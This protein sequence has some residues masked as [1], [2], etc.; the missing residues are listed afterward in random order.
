MK[1]IELSHLNT[2]LTKIKGYIDNMPGIKS[3]VSYKDDQSSIISDTEKAIARNNI[4]AISAIDLNNHLNNYV[5]Y[6]SQTKTESEQAQARANIMAGGSNPNL[7]M[8][9]DFRINQRRKTTAVLNEYIADGW[10]V[11]EGDSTYTRSSG[12][13]ISVSAPTTQYSDLRQRIVYPHLTGK[14]IIMSAKINGQIYV[15]NYYNVPNKTSA[16]V[17]LINY[18]F[19]DFVLLVVRQGTNTLAEL[20]VAVRTKN[21][22]SIT[23][24]EVKLEVGRYSTLA[25]GLVVDPRLEQF[26]CQQFAVELNQRNAPFAYYA[27]AFAYSETQAW[28]IISLPRPM[29]NNGTAP[30]IVFNNIRLRDPISEAFPIISAVTVNQN[31]SGTSLMLGL[32]SSGLTVGRTYQLMGSGTNSSIFISSEL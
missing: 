32:T 8:N 2:I 12:N 18:D 23:I 25:N 4:S 24:Q 20:V 22:K 7:L 10:I 26:K 29:F 9:G 6:S 27:P 30:N 21:G 11:T 13:T 14:D 1:Y 5:S 31:V 3:T 17:A 16:A 15:T 28:S 19:G